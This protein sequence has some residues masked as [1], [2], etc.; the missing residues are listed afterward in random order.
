MLLIASPFIVINNVVAGST[1]DGRH[2][3]L[4]VSNDKGEKETIEVPKEVCDRAGL[5]PGDTLSVTPNATG[6]LLSKA[7]QP[8][9]YLVTPDNA[10]LTRNHALAR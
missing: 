1:K 6:A 10:R 7:D 8:V 2:V 5:K 4:H 9:A 3:E